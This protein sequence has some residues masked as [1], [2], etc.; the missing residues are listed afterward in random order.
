MDMSPA[1]ED[2]LVGSKSEVRQRGEGGGSPNLTAALR[3]VFTRTSDRD[4]T[5]L[6]GSEK[7]VRN[8]SYKDQG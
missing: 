5:V 4:S 7:K 8:S 1:G 3:K 2:G 6:G